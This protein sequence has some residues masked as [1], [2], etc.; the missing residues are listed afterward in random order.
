LEQLFQSASPDVPPL[1]ST[2]R[3]CLL[4]NTH[5]PTSH[6]NHIHHIWPRGYGGTDDAE[7]KVIVC[8]TGHYNIHRL[9][10]EHLHLRGEVPYS[11]L[12]QFSREE[13]TYAKL[14]YDRIQRQAL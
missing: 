11:V 2:T 7:N 10:E 6:I 4:H 9:L 5:V 14:G 12:K 3:P 13:R 8:P 1:Y